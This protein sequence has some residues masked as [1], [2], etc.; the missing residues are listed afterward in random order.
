MAGRAVSPEV[1]RVLRWQPAWRAE[2]A[3]R[4]VPPGRGGDRRLRFV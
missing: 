4:R 2:A 1:W 3:V